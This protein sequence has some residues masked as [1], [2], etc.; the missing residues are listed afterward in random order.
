VI[1]NPQ[2]PIFNLLNFNQVERDSLGLFAQFNGNAAMVWNYQIG[3]RHNQVNLRAGQVSASGMMGMMATNANM[4]AMAFNNSDRDISHNNTDLV[5]KISRGLNAST[6]VNIDLGIKHRAPS[7]Q[8]TFLWIPLP[9]TAGLADGRSYMGNPG[10]DSETA[11][12]INLALNYKSDR[13]SIAPQL[14]YRHIDNYIQ[15]TTTINARANMVSTMMSGAPALMHSNVDAKIYGFDADWHYQISQN[16]SLDGLLSYVRGKRTDLSDNLYRIAPPNSRLS[17]HYHPRGKGGKL[18]LS[19]ETRLYAKQR[20]TAIFNNEQPSA[21]YSL[22]NI[23]GQ[24][25]ATSNLQVNAG[26]T[27]LFDRSYSNH[28]SGRNRAM[29]SDIPVGAGLPGLGRQLYIAM[30][31]HW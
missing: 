12:E 24:W 4:L 17:L 29:G 11:R 20:K 7:Y 9:I 30:Q 3:I 1:S 18:R 19:I 27:N 31:V 2:N 13:F 21:G 22:I 8:E 5:L 26:I 6:S 14:F 15:G 28:L 25:A 16:W 10:L 23:A